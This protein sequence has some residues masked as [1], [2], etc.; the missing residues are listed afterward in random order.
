MAISA[1]IKIKTLL[2]PDLWVYED[3][4][5]HCSVVFLNF[6]YLVINDSIFNV[7]IILYAHLSF[8]NSNRKSN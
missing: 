7:P 8:Y 6:I 4:K 1:N 2:N 3:P 5:E